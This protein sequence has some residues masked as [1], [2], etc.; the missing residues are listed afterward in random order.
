M[1]EHFTIP[2]DLKIRPCRKEDLLALEWFGM[3]SQ[4]REITLKNFE[5]YEKGEILMLVAEANNFPVGQ[6]Y[7]DLVKR[8]E[9][10][11]GVI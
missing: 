5:S 1:I 2:L 6:A 9:E 8:S 11:I 3:Y 4:F 7:I 10:S